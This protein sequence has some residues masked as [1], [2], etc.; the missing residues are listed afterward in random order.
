MI[1]I[2]FVFFAA[3]VAGASILIAQNSDTML[4]VNVLGYTWNVHVYWLVVAGLVATAVGLAGLLVMGR[5]VARY[6]RLRREHRGLV[7]DHERLAASYSAASETTATGSRVHDQREPVAA[8]VGPTTATSAP[9]GETDGTGATS[10][11]SGRLSR[12]IHPRQRG[13]HGQPARR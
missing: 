9:A 5:G 2:G 6:R 10:D 3:A 4:D 13:S 1:V 12:I 7:R 8:A 11:G